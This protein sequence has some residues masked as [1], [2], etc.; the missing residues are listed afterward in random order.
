MDA[1][2]KHIE[3]FKTPRTSSWQNLKQLLTQQ[4]LS[5]S[6]NG[7]EGSSVKPVI[8]KP[9]KLLR[10]KSRAVKPKWVYGNPWAVK[11]KTF[12]I[13][14]GGSFP[15]TST[16]SGNSVEPTRNICA[17]PRT[18]HYG[19]T[20][21]NRSSDSLE[22]LEL[23]PERQMSGKQGLQKSRKKSRSVWSVS[24]PASNSEV[25]N[26]ESRSELNGFS[27]NRVAPLP[28]MASRK[29]LIQSRGNREVGLN[30]N[31]KGEPIARRKASLPLSRR[32]SEDGNAEVMVIHHEEADFG[33]ETPLSKQVLSDEDDMSFREA[34]S[35]LEGVFA[36]YLAQ[37]DSHRTG[38]KAKT[39]NLGD[40][41]QIRVKSGTK[42]NREKTN[43]FKPANK[44][45]IRKHPRVKKPEVAH[46]SPD[47]KRP[48]YKPNSRLYPRTKPAEVKNDDAGSENA[49]KPT[50]LSL[51]EKRRMNEERRKRLEELSK[52]KSR[53]SREA[54]EEHSTDQK[55][56][57]KKATRNHRGHAKEASSVIRQTIVNDDRL[58]MAEDEAAEV[59]E[60]ALA[61]SE[62]DSLSQSLSSALVELG[63]VQQLGLAAYDELTN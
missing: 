12:L 40:G 56:S 5:V 39:K 53:P 24:S 22:F 30:G 19:K 9:L 17:R 31:E 60:T 54:A 8:L 33:S 59:L 34:R 61:E 52:P 37:P 63:K 32:K 45:P 25:D 48:F 38:D 50:K 62:S 4:K 28:S 57:S 14:D 21:G 1:Y 51:E 20:N 58:R 15:S 49:T 43:D 10:P 44:S 47:R 41:K 23:K 36:D 2:Y 27:F 18:H 55:T 7:G 29:N 13:R 46:Q 26:L 3:R 42:R 11:D 35:V 6:S 16:S